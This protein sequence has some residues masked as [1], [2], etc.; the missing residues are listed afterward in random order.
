MCAHQIEQVS[1]GNEATACPICKSHSTLWVRLPTVALL[2]CTKC[3]HCFTDV[4]SI[5]KE[6]SYESDYYQV[7][8][9]NWFKNPNYP[10]FS[11][12]TSEMFRYKSKVI[13]DVGCGNGAFL[14]YLEMRYL[15]KRSGDSDLQGID[16]SGEAGSSPRIEFLQGDFLTYGFEKKFD[17]VVTLAVIEHVSDVTSFV[18]RI[19]ELL[20]RN[21]IA[22]VMT[23]NEG[24]VLYRFANLLRKIGAASVFIRLYDPH[25]LNHFSKNSLEQLLTRDGLFR[26]ENH[27][28]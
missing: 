1:R 12:L 7:T 25:H 10:L 15:E 2:R 6:E 14:R 28:P 3:D 21:G 11:R 23:L 20:N 24:G 18:R 17:A 22:C 16:L 4:S 27:R 9:R 26:L 8:H 19:H 5:A 13:L